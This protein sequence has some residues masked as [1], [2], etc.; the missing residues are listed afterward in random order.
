MNSG[1]IELLQTDDLINTSLRINRKYLLNLCEMLKI[2]QLIDNQVKGESVT[3]I[4]WLFKKETR[5]FTPDE[6]TY[7]HTQIM[8]ILTWSSSELTPVQF[9]WN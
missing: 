2:L 9:R 7:L 5:L 6:V 1:K 8:F 3:N 4:K